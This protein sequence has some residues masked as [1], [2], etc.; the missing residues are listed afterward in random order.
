M[1]RRY[2]K[3]NDK[4]MKK[5]TI[6]FGLVMMLFIACSED[7]VK[8]DETDPFLPITGLQIPKQELAGNEITLQGKGF[9]KDCR[10][11]LQLNGGNVFDTEIVTRGEESLVFRTPLLETGFYVI[12][13]NQK[14]KTYRIGGIN[15]TR[16][17]IAAGDIEAYGVLGEENSEVY[18]ISIS[19]KLKGE[20][21]FSLERGNT[22]CGG[23]VADSVWYYSNYYTK[24][25]QNDYPIGQFYTIGAY[26]F[27]TKTNK[28]LQKD[29]AGF[30]A[31]GWMKGRLYII[32][33]SDGVCRMKEWA[34]G[35]FRE[36][37]NFSYRVGRLITINEGIFLYD[38]AHEA[39]VMSGRDLAGDTRKFV[40]VLDLV[41]PEIREIGGESEINF[42]MEVCG[43]AIY[44][45]GEKVIDRDKG[46]IDTYVL[47]PENPTQWLFSELTPEVILS[48]VAFSS[49]VYLQQNKVVYAI[50]DRETILTY[51]VQ[52]KR[53]TGGKWVNSGMVGLFVLE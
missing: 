10:I 49:P 9:D 50:D 42:R 3:T 29:I 13:L 20:L 41:H 8:T 34:D 27:R 15:L 24:Y 40:W 14:D 26:D 44:F 43:G 47:R 52:S 25:D 45:F 32:Q 5:S 11:Q 48:N 2:L 39:L 7:E 51:D 46:V 4:R 16:E 19:K 23:V 21:L 31:M 30:L 28:T 12:I 36:T 37:M 35:T 17:G 18:P 53:L 33:H 6:L 1:M 38:E 22:F